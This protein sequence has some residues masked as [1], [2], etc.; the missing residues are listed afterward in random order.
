MNDHLLDLGWVQ[1]EG[2]VDGDAYKGDEID[3][4]DHDP[5]VEEIHVQVGGKSR[6]D[7]HDCS[8][9]EGRLLIPLL[10]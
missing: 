9:V 10:S 5:E 6:E 4:D 1:D 7:L 8:R 2:F 3:Q